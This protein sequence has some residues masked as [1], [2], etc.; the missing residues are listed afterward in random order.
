MRLGKLVG[1]SAVARIVLGALGAVGLTLAASVPAY[2]DVPAEDTVFQITTDFTG[3]ELCAASARN[4]FGSEIFPLVPC[5]GGDAKQL[6]KISANGRSIQNV[7]TSVCL[8]DG[9]LARP[10]L[11]ARQPRGPLKWHQDSLGRVW[12]QGRDSITRTYWVPVAHLTHG[13]ILGFS[14]RTNGTIPADSGV[15][16][17]QEL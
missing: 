1:T 14:T 12:R 8:D 4:E 6:W 5:D 3:G 13:P 16:T 7:E 2:A 17:F 10:A 11:C 9:L 15:F